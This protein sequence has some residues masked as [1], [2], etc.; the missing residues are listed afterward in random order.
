MHRRRGASGILWA[1][2]K[3]SLGEHLRL[4]ELEPA[5]AFAGL[6]EVFL[7][8]WSICCFIRPARS[9]SCWYCTPSMTSATRLP[10]S[11]SSM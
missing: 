8:A 7:V 11:A 1:D 4:V 3:I 6:H 10:A 5:D 9:S 2:V